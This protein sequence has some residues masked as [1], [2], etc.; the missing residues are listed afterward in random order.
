[1]AGVSLQPPESFNFAD[2]SKWEVWIKRFERYRLLSGLSAKEENIQVATLVYSLGEKAEDIFNSFNLSEQH[3]TVYETVKSKFDTYFRPQT[4]HIFERAKLNVM[5]QQVGQTMA[6]FAV[7]LQKQ[8]LRCGYSNTAM[9]DECTRDRFVVGILDN[10]VSKKL[11]MDAELTLESAIKTAAQ[12]EE[13]DKQQ[14]QLS[15]KFSTDSVNKVQAHNSKGKKNFTKPREPREQPSCRWCGERQHKRQE[16]PASGKL[17]GRCKKMGHFAKVCKKKVSKH[18]QEVTTQDEMFLGAVTDSVC[19]VSNDDFKVNLKVHKLN[20]QFHIDTGADV[21]VI[22]KTLFAHSMPTLTSP[23]RM[24]YGPDNNKLN[25]LGQFSTVLRYKDGTVCET[26]FISEGGQKALLSRQAAVSLGLIARV[27]ALSPVSYSDKYKHVFEGLGKLAG[28][29]CSIKLKANATPQPIR[30]PRRI[31]LPIKDKVKSEL[32]RML[33]LGVIKNVEEPTE[34]CAPMVIV[35]KKDKNIRICVDYTDLNNNLI[36]DRTVLPTVDEV[37]GR[38]GNAKV[39]TKLDQNCGFWQVPLSEESQL[40]TAFITPWGRFCFTRLPFGISIGPEYYQA[41]MKEALAN[42]EGVEPLQDDT[43]VAGTDLEDHDRKLDMVMKALD[44]A[45]IRLNL[46]K[47]EFAVREVKFLGHLVG[48]KGIRTDPD[49]VEAINS[50]VQP[51]DTKDLLRFLGMVTHL[52]KFIPNLSEL[53]QPLRILLHKDIQW[54]WNHEQQQSFEKIKQALMTAP[55]LSFYSPAYETKVSSD[56]SSYGVGAV[57]LQRSS[58]DSAWSPVAYAS[59]TLNVAETRYAQIEKEA[60]AL[61]WAVDRFQDYLIGMKFIIETDHKPL[62]PI[63]STKPICELS[64]RLQRF[65]LKLTRY[66]YSIQYVPGSNLKVADAL[67]RAPLSCTPTQEELLETE[68]VALHVRAVM[69]NIGASDR[70]LEDLRKSQKEDPVSMELLH[71]TQTGWPTHK[72]DING[73]VSLFWPVRHELSIQEDLLV[74]GNRIVIPEKKREEILQKLHEG[75]MG[76]E[77]TRQRANNSVWWPGMSTRIKALVENCHVCIKQ[78]LPQTEPLMPTELPDYPWQVIGADL[79]QRG[80]RNY[81]VLTDYYSR[82]PEVIWLQK[83]TSESVV[84]AAKSIFSR[85]GYPELIRSDNGPQFVSEAFDSLSDQCGFRHITSSPRFPRSNGL[86][87]RSI[88]TVKNIISKSEDP[89]GGLLEFRCTPGPTGFSPAQLLM[90]RQPRTKIPSLKKLLRPK[91]VD[92]KVVRHL[93]QRN[94]LNQ[95]LNFDRRHRVVT[96][97]HIP[98]DST[99]WITDMKKEGRVTGQ[100]KTPRSYMVETDTGTLRRNTEHLLTLPETSTLR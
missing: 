64:T 25:I 54:V 91:Q 52:G 28:K 10:K 56:S 82:F 74:R 73:H 12:S 47:C 70:I 49:K 24:L 13:V 14:V 94:K 51:K 89:Y 39:F 33:S 41:R 15:N 46:K 1:M 2:S 44:K 96:R 65:R 38:L 72:R 17:C 93:D 66:N 30:A 87:E 83:T 5:Q 75:H 6:E 18:I 99:V 90:G 92:D 57:L 23:K 68:D 100:Y 67:S 55:T 21:T 62:V 40:L 79:C 59:R 53:C 43:I 69:A 42:C 58:K 27:N 37:L 7:A 60:L 35:W 36:R 76:I 97:D 50:F 11:Q 85:H 81:L 77:K 20:I 98:M 22:P 63:F 4:N 32:D 71:L 31:P 78:R 84:L 61:T 45:G 9:R 34:W 26:I 16:C 3:Q 80:N 86:I 95:K 48:E 88:K 29:P 8:A 19:R